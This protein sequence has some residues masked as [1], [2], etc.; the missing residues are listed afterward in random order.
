VI[1]AVARTASGTR[2]IPD[3]ALVEVDGDA[4]RVRLLEA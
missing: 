4:G 2:A 1:T 3:G